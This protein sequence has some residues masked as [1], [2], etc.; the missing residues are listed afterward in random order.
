MYTPN[1]DSCD[2]DASR[3]LWAPIL[4][5]EITEAISLTCVTLPQVHS[6]MVCKCTF[7]LHVFCVNVYVH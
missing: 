2:A 4:E 1:T 5:R 3:N 6:D 7:L